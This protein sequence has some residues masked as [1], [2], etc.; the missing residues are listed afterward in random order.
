M[1]L[2]KPIS[3]IALVATLVL[4]LAGCAPTL[5]GASLAPARAVTVQQGGPTPQVTTQTSG[6]ITVVGIGQASGSPDIARV[7]IGVETQDKDIK[8]AIADNNTQMTALLNSLKAAGIAAKD[9]QTMNYSVSVENPQVPMGQTG[10]TETPPTVIYHVSNQVNVTVRDI[11]KLSD[12]LDEAVTSGANTI[13]GVSF[14]V[15]DPVKL[16]DQARTQAVADAKAR[17]EKLAQL[18]G[19]TLG[20]ILTVSEVSA[21]PIPLYAAEYAM[22]KGGGGAPIESGSIQVTVNLQVTY[23]IK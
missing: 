22:G 15:S 7:V 10:S 5:T 9:I 18:E 2:W 23:A 17:A 6:G 4:A 12:V 14:D 20:N 11:T 1:S 13:Y 3:I 16:Q 21:S 19:L 8:K